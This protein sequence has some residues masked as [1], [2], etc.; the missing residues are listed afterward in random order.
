MALITRR[1]P[2][3][4]LGVG[5]TK[6]VSMVTVGNE[7]ESSV[8]KMLVICHGEYVS[9]VCVRVQIVPGVS[10]QIC[11]RTTIDLPIR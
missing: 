7:T 2:S 8:C 9:V 5:P 11:Q 3:D 4:S 1:S 6:D 10:R